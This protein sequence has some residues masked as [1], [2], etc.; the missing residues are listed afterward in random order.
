MSALSVLLVV[1]TAQGAPAA[2]RSVLTPPASPPSGADIVGGRR[3]EPDGAGGYRWPGTGFTAF[4]TPDGAVRFEDHRP[5]PSQVT[6]PVRAVAQAIKESTGRPDPRGGLGSNG[7]GAGG[8]LGALGRNAL[9]MVTNPTLVV[10]DEEL[11]HDSHHAAKMTFIEGTA[12]LRQKMREAHDRKQAGA[13][14]REARRAVQAIAADVSLSLSQRHQ[15]IFDLW[16][17]CD[18]TQAAGAATRTSIENEAGRQF[19]AGDRRGFTA[20]EL[21]RLN[22]SGRQQRF[23]PY[24]APT[25]ASTGGAAGPPP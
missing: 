3:L 25:E 20:A 21:Q 15:L 4:I 11:R 1:W 24:R 10:N 19:P 9:R 6:V 23:D 2:N 5:L 14:E 13:A 8:I 12:T 17:E 16:E 18:E 7:G 22:A